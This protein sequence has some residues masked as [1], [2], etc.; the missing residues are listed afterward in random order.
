M[1]STATTSPLA[2]AG[3]DPRATFLRA[4]LASALAIAPLGVW[5]VVH[6][7][8]NLSAFEGPDAWQAAVTEYPHPFAEA[9]TG[10]LV[11][12]PLAIH[13]VWGIGR[14]AS[15]RPNLGRYATYA[16]LKYVL[17]RLSS[18]GVLFFL[19]AH[20]W[21]AL[22]K[23]RLV[24]G[25]A[26]AFADISHEMHFHAPTLVVYVLGT[27]GVVYHLVNGTLSFCM[28]WGIVTSRAGLKRLEGTALAIFAVLL[29]MAWGA[30]Y[31]LWAAGAAA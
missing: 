17:Q 23:P 25:R 19:G 30:V 1:P 11:L 18:I 29:A 7:W 9:A 4:R 22:I 6:L 26:E 31:A 28:G 12:F 27:L 13:L 10:I 3:A 20:L 5:T 8:N 21:I 14:L 16:N 15:S 24:E 2:A